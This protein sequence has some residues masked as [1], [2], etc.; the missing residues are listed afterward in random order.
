MFLN[1]NTGLETDWN[2]DWRR[3]GLGTTAQQDFSHLWVVYN[4]SKTEQNRGELAGWRCGQTSDS[5]KMSFFDIM[6]EGQKIWK[7]FCS[8][9]GIFIK[10]GIQEFC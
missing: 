4:S 2:P 3:A 8:G 1:S 10:I 5:I 9:K 7:T 6:S